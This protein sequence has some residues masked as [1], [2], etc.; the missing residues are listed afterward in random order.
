MEH[1]INP[2]KYYLF[3]DGD[4]GFCNTWVHWVLKKDKD[5]RF[6]F[7]SLQSRLGQK[8]LR[9]RNLSTRDFNTLYIWKPGSYY[10]VKSKA[11]GT[12]AEVLGGKYAILAKL[13]IFPKF[14]SDLIYDQ[15]AKRRRKLA[16][17]FCELPTKEERRKF[18]D[19]GN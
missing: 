17:G 4:C 11:I 12:I 5:D 3:Y 18:V 15:V 9:E 6:L 1:Q 2:E 19:D 8:F 13:N 14:F 7:A 10:Q 16:S